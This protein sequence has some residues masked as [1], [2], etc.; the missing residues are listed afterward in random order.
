MDMNFPRVSVM[1]TID[2]LI[3]NS[4]EEVLASW[5]SVIQNLLSI[6]NGHML[7]YISK[8][9]QVVT[10][11]CKFPDVSEKDSSIF[12]IQFMLADVR[13][14]YLDAVH[15]QVIVQKVCPLAVTSTYI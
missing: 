15:N 5:V 4:N 9:N 13:L 11:I 12:A 7:Q 6:F 14:I 10:L 1:R 2:P 3:R 8:D